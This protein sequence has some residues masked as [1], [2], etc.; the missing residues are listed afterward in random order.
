MSQTTSPIFQVP[1]D[2]YIKWTESDVHIC[3]NNHCAAALLTFFCGWYEYKLRNIEKHYI[4]S[5]DF[6]ERDSLWQFQRLSDLAKKYKG[7]F[8]K[9]K[10][11]EA[12]K[13]LSS[14]GFIQIS[15]NPFNNDDNKNYFLVLPNNINKAKKK[16]YE[17]VQEKPIKLPEKAYK[18]LITPDVLESKQGSSTPDLNL[19]V[20]DFKNKTLNN[21][22]L[23]TISNSFSYEDLQ[24]ELTELKEKEKELQSLLESK[25][26]ETIEPTDEILSQLMQDDS[27]QEYLD[28]DKEEIHDLLL[29]EELTPQSQKQNI[30]DDLSLGK[31]KESKRA[32]LISKYPKSFKLLREL[33]VI[34]ELKDASALSWYAALFDCVHLADETIV[35]HLHNF[36]EGLI[37]DPEKAKFKYFETVCLNPTP[38][39][40]NP[41]QTQ[42]PQQ[43]T[44]QTP[45]E[46]YPDRSEV[47]QPLNFTKVKLCVDFGNFRKDQ[48]LF[49]EET[50]RG[51]LTASDDSNVIHDIPH[52]HVEPIFDGT[53]REF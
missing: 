50:R 21:I 51:W 17:L 33:M 46:K 11:G 7:L 15:K 30:E 40:D 25:N 45:V 14:L 39:T 35:N 32:D 9:N 48:E 41:S 12:I 38:R 23:N 27:N 53:A 52:K 4:D 1:N 13:E 8:G 43:N 49:F 36:I 19:K 20:P 34:R 47:F 24:N 6:H 22:S 10:I 29:S 18:P 44:N 3:N 42:H 5:G 28:P 26:L 37:A 31:S 2:S 16:Y